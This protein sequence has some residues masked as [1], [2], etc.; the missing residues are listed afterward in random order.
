MSDNAKRPN[1]LNPQIITDVDEEDIFHSFEERTDERYSKKRAALL[2]P[3]EASAFTPLHWPMMDDGKEV[4]TNAIGYPTGGWFALQK[5]KQAEEEARKEAERLAAEEEARR[6]AEEEAQEHR[7]TAEE[8]EE[9]RKAAYEEGLSEGHAEGLKQGYDAGFAKGEQEGRAQGLAQGLEEGR[10]QGELQGR[11]EGFA[12]GKAEGLE[13]SRDLVE[14]QVSR[15]AHLG[16]MLAN[17]LREINAAVTSQIMDMVTRLVRVIT[18]TELKSNPEHLQYAIGECL[19][20]LPDAVKGATLYLHPDDEALLLATL[21]R[22]YLNAQHWE[23]KTREDLTP[24]DVEVENRLSLVDFKV[25]ARL[26]ALVEKFL[27]N[28]QGVVERT[29]RES[30]EGAP[31]YDEL[32]QKPLA[33]PPDLSA[34]EGVIRQRLGEEESAPVPHAEAPQ[35]TPPAPDGSIAVPD[36]PFAAAAMAESAPARPVPKGGFIPGRKA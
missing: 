15:L 32:P 36:D 24:G 29:R 6:Q 4:S 35:D 17:P 13:N 30:I 3:K 16:D 1:D 8:V 19:K 18:H 5:K 12:R 28:A 34:L 7:L 9:I 20:L 31:E 10:A 2:E 23:V 11:E 14:S 25:D 33:P 21:G 27:T 26:D 22:D